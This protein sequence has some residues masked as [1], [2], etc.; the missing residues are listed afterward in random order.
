MILND[1]LISL[2][3]Q[4]SGGSKRDLLAK[5]F[6]TT[7]SIM[8]AVARKRRKRTT[9]RPLGSSTDD[10]SEQEAIRTCLIGE[11]EEQE[12]EVEPVQSDTAP[13][14]EAEEDE[15]EE[16]E[17]EDEGE[18]ET[19]CVQK[20][21]ATPSIPGSE[22]AQSVLLSEEE[23][24]RSEVKRSGG[25]R[26]EDARS[27]VSGYST[28]STLGRSL[29]SE[30][31][32]EDADDEQSELVSETDNE[33]GFASR[34]LTQERPEKHTPAPTSPNRTQTSQVSPGSAAPRSFL[35]TH[36]KSTPVS[37]PEPIPSSTK[38]KNLTPDPTERVSE[39][40]ARSSTPS[41]SSYSSSASQRLHSRPSFNSHRLIQC[42]TLA[43]RRL[44]SEKDKARSMDLLE[45]SSSSATEE[46][47]RPSV[48][49]TKIPE[50][51]SSPSSKTKLN[52]GGSQES[53][54]AP[55]GSG[56][57]RA[58]SLAEQ[59]RAR[60][61]GS[62]E[63]LRPAGLRK[64]LSPE[65]R[66]KRRAWRRHTVVA[67][68]TDSSS[69]A[70]PLNSSVAAS[71]NNNSKPPAPPPKPSA[72]IALPHCSEADAHSARRAPPTSRF[73]ECL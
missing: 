39:G 61:L 65:T 7:L 63:D 49:Q 58:F 51:F 21:K 72:A 42:D 40:A 19:E 24:Q 41:S 28:L 14:A 13:R 1:P 45:V 59:V 27:I 16:D 36:Y 73:H 47:P 8:S 56:E 26:G 66:R 15:D 67:S 50:S 33:S 71:N 30:G 48:G 52:R 23:D 20:D 32:G 18:R 64:P 46:D 17:E 34:S 4:G 43:R 62:A 68:P 31:R 12:Q 22:E 37:A 5:D 70:L 10:D 3:F 9:S 38:S 44:K 54:Q 53:T 55:S 29:A 25:W 60:L 2:V 11:G 57:G 69:K 6:L 35:Y